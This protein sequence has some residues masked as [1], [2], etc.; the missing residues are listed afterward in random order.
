MKRTVAQRAALGLSSAPM[1]A[2]SEVDP[3]ALQECY[4]QIRSAYWL[5]V[6]PRSA[7]L[8]KPGGRSHNYEPL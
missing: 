7:V 6:C 1:I 2:T 3:V 8:V 4:M 5:I